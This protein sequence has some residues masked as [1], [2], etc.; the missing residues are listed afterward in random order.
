MLSVFRSYSINQVHSAF[1][2]L[3][4][5]IPRK[6]KTSN[7]ENFEAVN[8]EVGGGG[9]FGVIKHVALYKQFGVRFEVHTTATMMS[10]I[11]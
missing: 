6:K 5:F 8:I 10:I 4:Y 9:I 2:L 3:T 1:Y 11:F 7:Y